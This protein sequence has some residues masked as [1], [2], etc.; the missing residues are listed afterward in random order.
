MDLYD[1]EGYFSTEPYFQPR[2]KKTLGSFGYF[3]SLDCNEDN[4]KNIHMASNLY[5]FTMQVYN[6][7]ALLYNKNIS[8]KLGKRTAFQP[9][10]TVKHYQTYYQ[11]N[12]LFENNHTV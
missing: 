2:H 8:L 9:I 12:N 5:T 7:V 1:C 10:S 3:H 11:M 6:N 4:L